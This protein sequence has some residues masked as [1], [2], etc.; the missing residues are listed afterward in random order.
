MAH[1][2]KLNQRIREILNVK[3]GVK[4]Q[5]MFGGLC[6]MHNGNMLCGA[7]QKHGLMVRV[8]PEQ[9]EEV[10]KL[11]HARK[12]DLTGVP[13]KGLIFVD[14]DGYKTKAELTKWIERGVNFT[15]TLPKKVKKK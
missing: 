12:M 1:D 3:K 10:I 4:E 2:E 15:N 9:Y 6:F 14:P 5:N 11:K 13:M 7:D 8:G